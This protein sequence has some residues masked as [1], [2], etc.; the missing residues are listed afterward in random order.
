MWQHARSKRAAHRA[1]RAAVIL[2]PSCHYSE[3]GQRSIE[4]CR[5]AP[6]GSGLC[7][8]STIGATLQSVSAK[9]DRE[10]T[11]NLPS[12]TVVFRAANGSNAACG[13][14]DP[15]VPKPSSAQ[16]ARSSSGIEWHKPLTCSE[17][18]QSNDPHLSLSDAN[19]DHSN[20]IAS[21]GG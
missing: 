6:Q 14:A 8:Y 13:I 5:K 2:K 21:R 15:P 17:L 7:Q 11:Q 10:G 3:P 1:T 19:R 18:G 16:S 20:K 9:F 4:L 12:T